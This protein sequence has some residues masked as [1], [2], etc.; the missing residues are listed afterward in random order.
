ML[1]VR[2]TMR[3]NKRA[4]LTTQEFAVRIRWQGLWRFE[5]VDVFIRHI[6]ARNLGLNAFAYLGFYGARARAKEAERALVAGEPMRP[7]HGLPSALKD[8]FDLKPSWS[9]SLGGTR[10]LR[11]SVV[12]VDCAARARMVRCHGSKR[13]K[14]C[15]VE[16]IAG[17]LLSVAL[18]TM[19]ALGSSLTLTATA[20]HQYK[21]SRYLTNGFLRVCEFDSLAQCKA[22]SSRCER[23]PFLKYCHALNG[24]I[25]RCD[26]DTL[27]EC[28]AGSSGLPGDCE[29]SPFMR[30]PEA[31]APGDQKA[32]HSKRK[33]TAEHEVS[34]PSLSVL[35]RNGVTAAREASSLIEKYR[36]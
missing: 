34:V 31:P 27:A 17:A 18:L 9:A 29:R 19:P 10:T 26:F 20:P 22:T 36:D 11:Y 21:Y 13:L 30:S 12:N 6:E 35:R 4:Y 8:P 3:S 28:E 1:G 15:W 23:Y 24:Q 7:M 32:Q 14:C 25:Q 33:T 16:L 5:V 2:W